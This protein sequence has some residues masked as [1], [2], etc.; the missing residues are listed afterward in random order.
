MSE[1]RIKLRSNYLDSTANLDVILP[2]PF[3][4]HDPERFYC[5]GKKYPVL[6]LLHGGKGK[7]DDWIT[8]STV[9]RLGVWRNTIIIAPEAPNSDFIN[10]EH[11]GEGYRYTDFFFHELMPFVYHWLPA[12]DRREDNFLLG[13]DMG[14]DAVWRYGILHPESFGSIAPVDCTPP[15]YSWMESWRDQTCAAFC[16]TAEKRQLH[17]GDGRPVSLRRR[18]INSIRKY[19]MV[20][21]F[22]D[23]IENTMPRFLE[24]AARG[25]LPP[26]YL[27]YRQENR[28]CQAFR[29]RMA[30]GDPLLQFQLF[31]GQLGRADFLEQAVEQFMDFA[32]LE[33]VE[34][35][36]KG[37]PI[38]SG[39]HDLDDAVGI[40]I[41]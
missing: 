8:Y 33:A 37:L 19:R 14:G 38:L 16:E 13:N 3:V 1:F 32:G 40:T 20:G 31:D 36:Q 18:Q 6:W 27:P 5:S 34:S 24:A 11:V 26:V 25:A 39:V 17:T 12:S 29:D 10:Q 23:S 21:D 30:G 28:Q 41:H 4:G 15:D 22:L 7:L 2:N 9:P 35:K